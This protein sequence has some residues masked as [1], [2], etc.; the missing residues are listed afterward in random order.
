MHFKFPLVLLLLISSLP[1][2][3]IFLFCTAAHKIH[4]GSLGSDVSSDV[5][6]PVVWCPGQSC[7]QICLVHLERLRKKDYKT[8]NPVIILDFIDI[9]DEFSSVNKLLKTITIEFCKL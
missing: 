5:S 3:L 8:P 7:S 6:Y 9:P 2:S 1:H 4:Q